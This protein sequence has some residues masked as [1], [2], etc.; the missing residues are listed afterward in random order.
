MTL[1]EVDPPKPLRPCQVGGGLHRESHFYTW[2]FLTG[3]ESHCLTQLLLDDYV[4]EWKTSDVRLIV[5][6]STSM[7]CQSKPAA[8]EYYSLHPTWPLFLFIISITFRFLFLELGTLVQISQHNPSW[9]LHML[10]CFEL[11]C[12]SNIDVGYKSGLK[13]LDKDETIASKTAQ[14][15]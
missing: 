15:L 3:L 2:R 10:V 6:P 13:F 12:F 4:Q 9:S 1:H 8:K 7:L 14:A 5:T 11:L